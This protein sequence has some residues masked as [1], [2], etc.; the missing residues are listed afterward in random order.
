MSAI[1]DGQS[2]VDPGLG[3]ANRVNDT[4][5]DRIAKLRARLM[6]PL[7]DDG[8]WGWV[9]PLLITVFAGVLR[10]IRLSSPDSVVFDETYYAKDAWSILRHG[11]EWNWVNPATPA[12]YVNNQI[13][14]GHFSDHL[15]QAC[16]GTGCG[17]YVVQPEVGKLLI[18]V[19]EW[20]Y[21]LTTLGWRFA[22]AVVGTLAILVM[23]RVARRLT[24]STLLGCT[25]GLLMSLDG[26]E[27]V[28]SRTGILDIFLMFFLLASFGAL[29]VDRDVSRAKLAELVVLQPGDPAGPA[30]GIRKWRVIAGVMLGLACASKQYAAWYVF[31]FAGLCIAWDLG[32]RRTAGLYGYRRGAWMRD[33][34]WL[35][36]TLGVIPLVTYAL[37]WMNWIVSGTGYDR[38]YA[39]QHGVGIPLISQ[40]YSL[41]EYHK[42]ILKFGV[43]L[44]S[45]HPY[46][47]Q[48]W[49]WF[50]MSR[51]VAFYW[52][53]YKDAAGLHA[54]PS[55]TV[56][57]YAS[58]V[59]AIGNPA[60]WWVSIPVI[61]FC[62]IWWLTRRDWRAGSALLCIAA[63]WAT[64]LPF[65]SRTKFFYYA[66]EFEPFLI[67][68][69]VLCLGLILG[70]AGAS[71]KRRGT[72]VV[73]AGAYVLGVL[74]LF[75]YFYPIMTGV[76]IPYGDWLGHMWYQG[77]LGPA[78]GWI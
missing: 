2:T 64:W 76:V 26:L 4:A 65:V 53:S 70:P 33:G 34:K 56:G 9:W 67:V 75:G 23:C 40:L 31:A 36:L 50:V 7:P 72:G 59:T 25:A 66:L 77:I 8:I 68:C 57:P 69:I 60:I 54:E 41:Y 45:G 43:G 71:L 30:L 74:I 1:S 46:M 37:T 78:K 29:V 47:S 44:N 12:N 24:R 27:F 28:L 17:E 22:S 11:V 32:A 42:E 38:D 21:G 63:G 51:P 10:F 18:A 55:G 52:V 73:I 15:F 16:S 13:I 39:R 62:L 48:P 61:L 5:A 35:P 6:T 49:D 3:D 19:G 14:A 58:A 20:M